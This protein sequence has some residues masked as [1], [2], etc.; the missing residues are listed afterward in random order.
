MEIMGYAEFFHVTSVNMSWDF[1]ACIQMEKQ[2]PD[3]IFRFHCRV[4]A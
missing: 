2:M 3:F 1:M 4:E